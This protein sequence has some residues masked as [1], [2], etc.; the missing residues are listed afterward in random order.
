[1]RRF[2]WCSTGIV[3][4]LKFKIGLTLALLATLCLAARPAGAGVGAAGCDDLE[5]IPETP[6]VDF[7]SQL[8]PIFDGCANCHGQMGPAGL[9]LRS[10]EAYGNLVGVLSTTNPARLRVDPFD[11]EFSALFLAV[12][13]DSPGGPA[14]RMPG[15]TPEE[16]ALIRD[17]IAQGAPAEPPRPVPV[18]VNAPWALFGLL[19]LMLGLAIRR[20]DRRDSV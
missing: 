6:A 15:T 16:R 19:C 14:F 11:P 3:R 10:G 17:W 5:G 4:M 12:S 13:C 1:M 7:Q 9:D 8:Q 18:P 20:L 2:D